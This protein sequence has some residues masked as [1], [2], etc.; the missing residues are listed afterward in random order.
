MRANEHESTNGFSRSH[1]SLFIHDS[2]K[3]ASFT[4]FHFVVYYINVAVVGCVGRERKAKNCK[5]R[6]SE[7]SLACI[8]T[9]TEQQQQ[10]QQ[11]I[12]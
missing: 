3:K 6:R 10:Q 12:I 4:S 11:L 9:L 8:H 2:H 1:L 5:R 7:K